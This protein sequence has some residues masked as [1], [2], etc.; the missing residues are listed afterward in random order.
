MRS[1]LNRGGFGE[2][3]F[4]SQ[5]FGEPAKAKKEVPTIGIPAPAPTPEPA[6]EKKARLRRGKEA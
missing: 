6:P 4:Q 1:K 2:V 3:G 5:A